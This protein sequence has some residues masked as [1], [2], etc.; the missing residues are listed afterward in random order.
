MMFELTQL[1]EPRITDDAIQRFVNLRLSKLI[2]QGFTLGMDTK[3]LFIEAVNDLH[4]LAVFDDDGDFIAFVDC[5]AYYNCWEVY[6]EN[7]S[8]LIIPI[9]LNV[10]YLFDEIFSQAY[11]GESHA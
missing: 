4:D 6:L 9:T 1:N 3:V 7:D 10:G 5:H 2:E 8:L 11:Q